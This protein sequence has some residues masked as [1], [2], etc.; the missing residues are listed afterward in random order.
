MGG[1]ISGEELVYQARSEYVALFGGSVEPELSDTFNL[2]ATVV[3]KAYDTV[4][5]NLRIVLG[6]DNATYPYIEGARD[7]MNLTDWYTLLLEIDVSDSFTAT[8]QMVGDMYR[9]VAIV[10]N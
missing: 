6:T 10:K 4:D 5:S 8:V 3:S 9:I 2:T 7:W 1:E